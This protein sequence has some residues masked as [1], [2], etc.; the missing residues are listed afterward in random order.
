MKKETGINNKYFRAFLGGSVFGFVGFMGVSLGNFLDL[1]FQV[2]DDTATDMG[3]SC[4]IPIL[5]ITGSI[6][7]INTL[8]KPSGFKGLEWRNRNTPFEWSFLFSF[9]YGVGLGLFLWL[10][11]NITYRFLVE[12]YFG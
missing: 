4:L 10:I 8:L 7:G 12:I 2:A 1:Y 3:T 6:Y 11:L 9:T 5:F